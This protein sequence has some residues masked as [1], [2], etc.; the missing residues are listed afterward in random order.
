M[1]IICVDGVMQCM[2]VE[3]I[4]PINKEGGKSNLKSARSHLFSLYISKCGKHE[5]FFFLI[6]LDKLFV[7]VCFIDLI[8]N[9]C[10]SIILKCSFN[11]LF[12]IYIII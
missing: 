1:S 7:D 9:K 10:M 5:N 6:V 12:T 11:W 4:F 8:F 3:M 2:F